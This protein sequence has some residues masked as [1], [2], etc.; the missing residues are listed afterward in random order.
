MRKWGI[1][2]AVVIVAAAVVV[3]VYFFVI[4]KMGNGDA[5]TEGATS[6]SGSSNSGGSSSGGKKPAVGIV[7][8]GDGSTVVAE[9]GESF[10]YNNSFGGYW[11][12]DASNPFASGARPN[13]WTPP[14]NESWT[15]G[16][17]RVYGV[18][19]G[20]WFVLE[21]FISPA[22]FQAY[23]A[24]ADEWDL[25]TAMRADGTL[26]ATMEKHYAEFITEKDIA[27]IAG[28]GLNWVRVPIPF[29]AVSTWADVGRAGDGSVV[30]EPFLEGVCWKYIVRLLGWARKYGLRVNLDLHSVPGSQN[31]YN[32]SGKLGQVNFLNG[33]MGVANAQRA[34][35]VIRIISEFIAQPEYQDVVGM[36]G[37]VNEALMQVIGR[38]V[39]TSFYLEA[40]R[41][42]REITGLGAGKGPYISIHDGFGG[43]SSWAGFLEGS[44]RIILDTHPYFSFGGGPND[45]PIATSED[46]VQAGG[47]WPQKACSSWGPGALLFLYTSR[48]AF[49]VTVAGE[50]SNGYNDCGMYLTGVN[51]TA[52]YPDCTMWEDASMWNASAKAGVMEFARASMDA[53][54]DW[55]FWTWKIGPALDGVVRAPLWSYQAGL[56]GGWMPTDPRSATGKCAQFN[57]QVSSFGGQ[58]KP[59]Q[60]G[61]DGAGTIAATST[62][63]FGQWP[64]ASLSTGGPVYPTYTPTGSVATL[65]YVTP[66]PT[67]SVTA[68]ATVSIGSG[69]AN[70]ADRA[71]GVTAI[72]GCTYPNA[73]G[74][75]SLP[76]PTGMC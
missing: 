10:V 21:P 18:N 25:S 19:L 6:T 20:G 7:T 40:H 1:L 11:L 55:F 37:I 36:F 53:F 59:W 29:W 56:E 14:L 54:G 45:E 51:G 50:F 76:A 13:S 42:I 62:Q 3:P 72:A 67:G 46:P 9:S 69:W 57:V 63:Q 27:Q 65:S 31:G 35:D 15:W 39:I 68:S 64:P 2:A 47:P 33:P 12:A 17:D 60:T 41:M 32:H 28:A 48:S 5:A 49:G 26:E 71:G 74:A 58:F 61:G 22:L 24:A 75:V 70:A 16:K 38:P 4:R 73:W 52:H 34:L 66:T 8:G 30:S 43:V 44:D 23:P